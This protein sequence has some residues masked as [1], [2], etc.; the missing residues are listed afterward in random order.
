[1]NNLPIDEIENE[2]PLVC[3]AFANWTVSCMNGAGVMGMGFLDI[4]VLQFL[5]KSDGEKRLVGICFI[6]RVE[7]QHTVNYSL[8]KLKREGLVESHKKGKIVSYTGTSRGQST[9]SEFRHRR[10][11][12]LAHLLNKQPTPEGPIL[13]NP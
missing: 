1:M 3:N 9:F 2:L 5:C 6:L 11:H 13:I 7:D 4:L 10:H 12:C 8:K